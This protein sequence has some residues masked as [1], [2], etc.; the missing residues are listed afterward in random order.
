[1]KIYP[2]F[3]LNIF[4]VFLAFGLLVR[5]YVLPRLRGLPRDQALKVLLMPHIFR[6]VG[7]SFLFPGV[8]SP[9]LTTKLTYPAAWGDFG[10][11][12]LAIVAV[13]GISGRWPFAVSLVWLFNLWGSID[14]IYAY[15]NGIVLHL[16]PG[17]L[18]ATY[19][20]PTIIVP[21]L[22][23]THALIFWLLLRPRQMGHA[24]ADHL[25]NGNE[26]TGNRE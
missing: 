24:Y 9:M 6:F 11:A 13:I 17:L 25:L 23:V 19:Y 12:V 5:L 22:L 3:L 18:G 7:L 4:G 16:E 26:G 1:M 8:V 14:L 15:Y 2:S 21:P 20:I 10:A